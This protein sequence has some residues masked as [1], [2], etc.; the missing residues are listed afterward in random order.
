MQI[1]LRC[2]SGT[3]NG[4]YRNVIALQVLGAFPKAPAAARRLKALSRRA[5]VADAPQLHEGSHSGEH[6]A[7]II[8]ALAS[9]GVQMS[10]R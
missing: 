2:A 6:S 1:R 8:G 3:R 7:A 9:T 4:S 5:R 10:F